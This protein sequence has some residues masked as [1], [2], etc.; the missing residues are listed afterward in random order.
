MSTTQKIIREGYFWTALFHDCI[1]IVKRCDKCQCYANKERAPPTLLHLVITTIPFYKW[2][3]DFMTFHPS[4]SNGHK[5]IIV[6]IDYFTKWVKSMPTFNNTA[7]TTTR[8]LFNH[9]FTQFRV[10]LQLVSDHGK[11]FE[12]EIFKE[13]SSKL[14]F[15][16]EFSS[17]YYPQSNG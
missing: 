11:H 13:L 9:A 5:Y 14:G 10:P 16:H 3:I 8:V 4:S 6:A 7:D 2:G 1:H 15:S 12:N 17:P